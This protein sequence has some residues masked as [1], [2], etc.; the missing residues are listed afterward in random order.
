MRLS[1]LLKLRHLEV[2]VEVAR[3]N[4]VTLAG[5]ALGLTQPAVTRALRELEAVCE[6]PLVERDGRGIRLTSYGEMFRDHA[7]RSLALARD[8]VEMLRGLDTGEG[9]RLA[10][11]ALPTV[12][13]TLVPDA[14]ARLNSESQHNR[15]SVI[16]GDNRF[17]LDQLRR[18]VLDLVVGRLPAPDVMVGIDFEPLFH[19]QVAVVVAADHPLAQGRELPAEALQTYPVVMPSRGAII[20]P[21][22]EQMFLEQGLTLPRN[23]I[24][25][26][27]PTF[28]R[29]FVQD[30]QGIWIISEG[31]VQSELATGA[32]QKLL[33]NT[34]A[35]RGAVGLCIR[36]EHQLTPTGRRFCTV[37]RE[38]CLGAKE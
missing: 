29:R 14:L 4:S 26:V 15:F 16:T 21:L 23:A 11:G 24:E 38:L 27:S 25:T 18:G 36:S 8:G 12:S 7:G 19:E 1:A 30:H 6:K 2:F 5:E 17:L 9:P 28:G 35:T 10:I 22:V 31:V 13:A 34:D 20:R 32:F 3:Q 33:L 37:V